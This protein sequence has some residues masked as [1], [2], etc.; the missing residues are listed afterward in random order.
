MENITPFKEHMLNH[1]FPTKKK[2][3]KKKNQGKLIKNVKQGKLS[4]Q[5]IKK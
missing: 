4:E 3:K 5:N 2:K 1:C